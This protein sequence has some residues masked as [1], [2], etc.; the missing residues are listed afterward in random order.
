MGFDCAARKWWGAG[1]LQWRRQDDGAAEKT[2]VVVKL[3]AAVA[4]ILLFI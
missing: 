4:I 1:G 3:G 2:P